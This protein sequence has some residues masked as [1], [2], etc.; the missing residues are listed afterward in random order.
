MKVCVELFA[1]AREIAGADSIV[2][3]LASGAD[4]D[5]LRK[6]LVAKAPAL[7]AL[8]GAGRFAAAARYVEDNETVDLEQ[9]IAFIPPVSGG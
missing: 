3:D 1:G 6:A 8:A 2:L 5:D 7:A 9:E 4:Y